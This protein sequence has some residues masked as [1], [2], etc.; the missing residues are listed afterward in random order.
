MASS[1]VLSLTRK[2][3]DGCSRTSSWSTGVSASSSR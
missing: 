3:T 2:K 1:H